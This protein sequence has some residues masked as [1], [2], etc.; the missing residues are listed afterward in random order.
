MLRYVGWAL[1][2]CSFGSALSAVEVTAENECGVAM[3]VQPEL[4]SR[5]PVPTLLWD[6]A[7][8]D[9]G[10]PTEQETQ[11]AL[12][13]EVT[14]ECPSK[15]TLLILVKS[16]IGSAYTKRRELQRQTWFAQLPSGVLV[17][18]FYY[19]G[20]N[21]ARQ[22]DHV[23]A[24]I[25]ALR[26]ESDAHGD[27]IRLPGY[28]ESYENLYVK[29]FT[30]LKWISRAQ[31]EFDFLAFADDDCYIDPQRALR[32]L[33]AVPKRNSEKFY[34]GTML[35][36][37]DVAR[38]GRHGISKEVWPQDRLPPFAQ[39]TF[40]VVSSDIVKR[41]NRTAPTKLL[42]KMPDDIL[43]GVW[44]AKMGIPLHDTSFLTPVKPYAMHGAGTMAGV[45]EVR[46]EDAESMPDGL[47]GD[48]ILAICNLNEN[49][50]QTVHKAQMDMVGQPP[51]ERTPMY[52]EY[53]QLILKKKQ[54]WDKQQPKK[55]KKV[56]L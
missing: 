38:G 42:L 23:D 5:C 19:V 3:P 22:D 2:F 53:W 51:T 37:T 6:E 29:L 10:A 17:R 55:N 13:G 1:L 12:A 21:T 20:S 15:V 34:M 25:R 16:G 28:T 44:T 45:W 30:V 36:L 43:M 7:K 48:P 4:G 24:D 46:D 8:P 18:A 56:K 9:N 35:N 14:R 26:E 33:N 27:I 11:K 47:A 52:S 49:E 31:I 40:I 54:H 50:M 41:L 39:G 32:F